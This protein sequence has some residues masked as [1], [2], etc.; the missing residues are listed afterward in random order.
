[1]ENIYELISIFIY[2]LIVKCKVVF[3]IQFQFKKL[4][5][6]NMTLNKIVF[7]EIP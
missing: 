2:L 5:L 6:I 4:I 1:M 3:S 7:D